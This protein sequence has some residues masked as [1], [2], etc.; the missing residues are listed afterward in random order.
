MDKIAEFLIK[1][2]R[3]AAGIPDLKLKKAPPALSL[4]EFWKFVVQK[5]HAVR[6]GPHY[7][8]RLSDGKDAHSWV[9]RH[10]LPAPGERRLAIHQPTHR[11][12]FMKFEG[13]LGRGYGKGEVKIDQKGLARVLSSSPE[14]VQFALLDK[15]DPEEFILTKR[16]AGFRPDTWT[17]INITPTRATKKAI[18]DAKPAYKDDK[19]ENLDKYLDKDYVL[20]P[21]VDG[22]HVI[23]DLTSRRPRAYSYRP[24]QR[25]DRLIQHT[26]KVEGL[27]SAKI[28]EEL[29]GTVLR[30]ELYG[31]DK[32]T[33]RAIAS[34]ELGAVL[35]ATT[36]NSLQRQ[37]NKG[38]TLRNIIFDVVKHKGQNV[39]DEDY[40]TKLKILK[41]ITK[42]M[43]ETFK[44]P[45]LATSPERKR[46]LLKE[47]A[48]GKHK[49]TQEGVVAWP[50]AG[51]SRPTRMK[52]RPEHDVVIREIVPGKREGMAGALRYS[53]TPTGEVVGNVG[54]GFS[55]ATRRDMAQNPINYLGRVAKVTALGK[56]PSGAL[57]APAFHSLHLDK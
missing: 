43:P 38:I 25:S 42:L 40:E 54:T 11:P 8:L 10:G 48:S 32:S 29:R 20:Q 46:E 22:S 53:F 21:K 5:H 57:R 17:A 30:G 27:D 47:I 33:G 36:E 24:S 23:W 2:G 45:E 26:Y 37:K 15:R 7:D 31:V 51:D 34:Q 52:L 19:P 12:S 35:N 18:P 28:P 56:F 49:D 13:K 9:L 50:V 6:A 3:Q 41:K 14:H 39:E 55:N 1:L 44:L 4:P 16:K